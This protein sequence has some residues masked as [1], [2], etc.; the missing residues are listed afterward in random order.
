MIWNGEPDQQ[1]KQRQQVN[2]A[3]EASFAGIR[4]IGS[5]GHVGLLAG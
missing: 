1:P 2:G 3:H 4:D 5:I